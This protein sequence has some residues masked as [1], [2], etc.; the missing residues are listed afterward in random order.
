MQGEYTDIS[1]K[2]NDKFN[3]PDMDMYSSNKLELY[4]LII[5]S[6]KFN[7]RFGRQSD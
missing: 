6:Y 5:Y 4:Q 3:M 7:T 1:Y 2:L